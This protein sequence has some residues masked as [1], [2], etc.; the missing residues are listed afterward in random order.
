MSLRETSFSKKRTHSA[1]CVTT[2]HSHPPSAILSVNRYFVDYILSPRE[3][4]FV[5]PFT[6]RHQ[7]SAPKKHTHTQKHGAVFL[8]HAPA[9]RK[10]FPYVYLLPCPRWKRKEQRFLVTRNAYIFRQPKEE[11]KKR[12]PE[13]A[14]GPRLYTTSG[15]NLESKRARVR[16]QP[17]ATTIRTPIYTHTHTCAPLAFYPKEGRKKENRLFAPPRGRTNLSRAE[18]FR[19]RRRNA[20]DAIVRAARAISDLSFGEGRIYT[21]NK[22]WHRSVRRARPTNSRLL[23]FLV[24]P[25]PWEKRRMR[26]C[27]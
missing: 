4:I 20:R 26:R 15:R 11:K 2:S 13:T 3:S 12:F 1:I 22:N 27:I 9:S 19:R 5:S 18:A 25:P 6:N 17:P 24:R 14:R 8:P 23:L 7:L 21:Y 10:T 16:A